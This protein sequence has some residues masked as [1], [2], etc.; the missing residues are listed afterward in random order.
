VVKV[1]IP[2]QYQQWVEKEAVYMPSEIVPQFNRLMGTIGSPQ[3]MNP[4]VQALESVQNTWKAWTLFA[5]P[6]SIP[7]LSRNL[8]TGGIMSHLAGALSPGGSADAMKIVAAL[9]R[10]NGNPE[11]LMKEAEKLGPLGEYLKF[12]FAHNIFSSGQTTQEL[13]SKGTEAMFGSPLKT[14]E[15]YVGIKATAQINKMVEAYNRSQHFMTRISQGWSKESA[16][17]DTQLYQYDY[18]NLPDAIKAMKLPFPF[19]S[20]MYNNVP[21]MLEGMLKHPGKFRIPEVVR[22]NIEN[23]TGMSATEGKPNEN[24]L[25]EFIKGDLHFRLWQDPKSGNWTYVRLASTIPQADL[26]NIMG[27]KRAMDWAMGALTPFAKVPLETSMNRSFFFKGPGGEPAEIER[28][29]GETAPFLGMNLP[30]KVINAMKT[31]RMS[32]EINRLIPQE[33]KQTLSPGEQAIRLAGV[34]MAPVS[35]ENAGKEGQYQFR[36]AWDK[37]KNALARAKARGD[38]ANVEQA[39]QKIMELLGNSEPSSRPVPGRRR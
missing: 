15:K 29:P 13:M 3:G 37:Y 18:E 32:N 17:A 36:M 25:D 5:P 27:P 39:R 35:L 14:A 7:Y 31:V 4:L 30:K 26:E 23:T 9:K 16:L 24:A 2:K 20:W 33:G 6:S 38:N 28:Y 19:I 22:N 8:F 1:A 11:A 10:S 21:V 34:Q 12:L